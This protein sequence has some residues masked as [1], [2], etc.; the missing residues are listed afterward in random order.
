MKTCVL[1]FRRRNGFE[2]T[3][4]SRSRWN[5]VRWS[6]SGSGSSRTAGYERMAS[7]ESHSS[8]SLSIRSLNDVRASCAIRRSILAPHSVEGVKAAARM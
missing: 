4:R 8:S 5:G 6:E 1:C 7:G 2:C 3:I